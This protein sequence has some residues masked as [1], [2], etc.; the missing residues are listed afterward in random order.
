MEK[1]TAIIIGAGS[2][3]T[4]YAEHMQRLSDRFAVVG[5]AE[6]IAT[7][8]NNIREMFHIP[9]ENCSLDYKDIL[10]QPKLADIAVIAT[11]DDLHTA[12][13]LLAIE[14][15]Y[16]LL[17]EKPLAQTP[18]ECIRIC[19]AA[20]E[21]GVRVLVCHV[22]RYTPFYRTVKKA[23]MDGAIGD[24]MSVVAVEGV[25][26]LHQSHSYVRGDWKSEAET[27]PMLLA[28]C[29]HD[30][31]IIQ[32]LLDKPCNKVSSFGSLTYFTPENAPKGAPHRCIDTRCPHR[33]TCYYDVNKAYL[34]EDSAEFMRR[35][36][37]RGFSKAYSPTTAEVLEG[38]RNTNFGA[39]VFHAGNDVVDHQV[40]HMEFDGGTTA[41]LTM[42][43]FNE[44]GRYI[45]LFGTKGELYANAADTEI[46]VYSFDSRQ[47]T[48]LS[49][50]ETEESIMGGHGGGDGGIVEELYDYLS[51]NYT[52]F[53]AADIG[54][55][56]R[57]HLIGFAAERA[58]NQCTVE[59]VRT[60][61]AQ[62]KFS[63]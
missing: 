31:D 58:R 22:L 34:Q 63:Y 61:A 42:N 3:G 9:Q 59:D 48:T 12:P 17:L 6:P 27:T 38:L 24:V 62:L 53:C 40:I 37:A 16:D 49:V 57:N 50:E 47:T 13:A 36:A 35:T 56:V 7:R 32:W 23:V 44:G 29:C 26:H 45:R 43:A 55:S 15:G 20:E 25:G 19:Q 54:I 33:E 2:R 28:K 21:K 1:L 5:V 11:M 46:T 60:Y 30:L 41:S 14:K 51:G 39:C 4:T 18:E 8:R 52:G 10:A